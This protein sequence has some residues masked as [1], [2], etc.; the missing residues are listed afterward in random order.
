MLQSLRSM[1]RGAACEKGEAGYEKVTSRQVLARWKLVPFAVDLRVRRLRWLQSMLRNPEEHR[2]TIA[3]V[4]GKLLIVEGEPKVG[5][6]GLLTESA[7]SFAVQ[8]K[9]MWRSSGT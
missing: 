1:L 4:W 5:E 7:N 6:D 8:W 2:Q 3:A 9:S